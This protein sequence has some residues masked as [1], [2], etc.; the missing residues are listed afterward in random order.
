MGRRAYGSGWGDNYACHIVIDRLKN[1]AAKMQEQLLKLK[2]EQEQ[3]ARKANQLAG[4]L[5]YIH[6]LIEDLET[7]DESRGNEDNS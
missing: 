3:A 1:D 5:N 2:A 4:A 7:A 6:A